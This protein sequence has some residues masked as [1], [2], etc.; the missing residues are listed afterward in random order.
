[1]KAANGWMW[2]AHLGGT[3]LA[4]IVVVGSLNMDVVAFAARIPVPGE[5]I[6]GH[7]FFT[8]PGGKGANQAYACAR[9]EGSTA[10]LGR[11][12]DDEFGR[13]LCENLRL[14]G[15]D[16]SGILPVEGSSGV[17]LIFVAD[18]GQNSIVVVPGANA[19]FLAE[20]IVGSADSFLGVQIVLLQLETP[21][22]TVLAAAQAAKNANARVILDPAPADPKCVELF[23]FVDILTP[24]ET[25][26]AVLA[27]ASP[28]RL[29]P[30]EA[31]SI[32]RKLQEQGA[33]TVIVKLGEQGCVLVE[34]D[35]ALLMAAPKVKAVDTTAA[36]DVFNAGLAVALSE[37]MILADACGY[38]NCAAAIAVTRPGAQGAAPSRMDVEIFARSS[39]LAGPVR[40]S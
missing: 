11:V 28:S 34:D 6:F 12:G 14:T 15:C 38:A 18:S 22:E 9:L 4:K 37:G 36:G 30:R 21:M 25:E 40:I 39:F 29:D 24:N 16:V 19:E 5:T 26:A 7:S 27:G 33:G 13:R 32:A 2:F 20:H 35:E 8:A 17:A 23:P 3:I 10:M 1:L 31:A